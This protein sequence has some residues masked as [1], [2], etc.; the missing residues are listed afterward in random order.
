MRSRLSSSIYLAARLSHHPTVVDFEDWNTS[1][2]KSQE[3]VFALFFKAHKCIDIVPNSSKLVVF[4][5]E[6]PVS[7]AFFALVYNGV[8]AAPL[9]DSKKQE[10]VGMLTITDFIQIL[11][12]YYTSN[13]MD[14]GIRELEQHKIST[15][16]E[17]FEADGHVKPVV[18]IGPSESLY[19][20]VQILCESK[21]HRLPVLEP[22]TGDICYILT[23][24]RLM[25]FLYLYIN[26]LPRPSFMDKTP[27]ELGIGSWGDIC[28]VSKDTPL[29]EAMKIFLQ[30]RVSALPVVDSDG[31]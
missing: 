20:A 22:L 21:I 30:K 26:D 6:L 14:E 24:K 12:R 19:R 11:H 15:W 2:H 1:D 31:R 9:W 10:F 25:K 18:T 29:I 17:V 4:D 7:K 3:Q 5:T 8:R 13:R 23:H 28:T 27:K 16:R